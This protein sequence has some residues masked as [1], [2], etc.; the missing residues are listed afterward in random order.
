MFALQ[1]VSTGNLKLYLNK[2][3]FKKLFYLLAL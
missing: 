3:I 2:E 1:K